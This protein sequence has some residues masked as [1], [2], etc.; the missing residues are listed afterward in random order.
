MDS[1]SGYTV[2]QRDEQRVPE[3]F[4]RPF[5]AWDRP[6]LQYICLRSAEASKGNSLW[7]DLNEHCCNEANVILAA[8]RLTIFSRRNVTGTLQLVKGN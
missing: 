6:G 3:A 5:Q 4:E 7:S 2:R 8:S 1:E